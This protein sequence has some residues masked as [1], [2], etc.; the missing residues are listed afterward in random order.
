MFGK[1]RAGSLAAICSAAFMAA[2]GILCTMSTAHAQ[3]VG[4]SQVKPYRNVAEIL[5]DPA[6]DTHVTLRGHTPCS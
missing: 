6:D 2:S 4:P 5:K 1:I 3:Y